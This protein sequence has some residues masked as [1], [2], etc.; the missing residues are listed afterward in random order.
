MQTSTVENNSHLIWH[1]ST[2]F[3]FS[4]LFMSNEQWWAFH[5]TKYIYYYMFMNSLSCNCTYLCST[6]YFSKPFIL[7]FMGFHLQ[8]HIFLNLHIQQHFSSLYCESNFITK[9]VS[10]AP[11]QNLFKINKI[12]NGRKCISGIYKEEIYWS[13]LCQWS[14]SILFLISDQEL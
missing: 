13:I 12:K 11:N 7:T 1:L 14:L 9:F 2:R 4:L 3:A 8:K 6:E 5:W 10:T